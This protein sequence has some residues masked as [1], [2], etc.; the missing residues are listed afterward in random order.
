MKFPAEGGNNHRHLLLGQ[1][2]DSI[3]G[4]AFHEGVLNQPLRSI[5]AVAVTV[6]FRDTE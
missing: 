6:R 3:E 1:I 5:E 2:V 4:G